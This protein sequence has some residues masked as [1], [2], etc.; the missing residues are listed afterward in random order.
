MNTL[1]ERI[2]EAR[3]ALNLSQKEFSEKIGIS[4]RAVSWGEQPGNNVPD[5]TIKSL[6]LAFHINESWLRFGEGSMFMESEAFSL[7]RFAKEHGCTDLEYEILRAYFEIDPETRLAVVNHFKER[8]V[9][10]K[11]QESPVEKASAPTGSEPQTDLHA[12]LEDLKQQ[13]RAL[14][15]QKEEDERQKQEMAAEIIALREEDDALE[16]LLIAKKSPSHSH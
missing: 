6:C 15:Q 10:V 13:M 16:R 8:L 12:E 11:R 7:D 4:Q 3:K 5:S 9:A 1:N 14:M 2:K